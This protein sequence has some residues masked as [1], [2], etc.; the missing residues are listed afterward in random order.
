[1]YRVSQVLMYILKNVQKRASQVLI[2]QKRA[3]QVLIPQKR[4]SQVLIYQNNVKKCASQIFLDLI[5]K[6]ASC[7]QVL[8]TN[9]P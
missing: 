4:A 9:S 2:P 7:L 5:H 8:V 1:M 6:L 3:S